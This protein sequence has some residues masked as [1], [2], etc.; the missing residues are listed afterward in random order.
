MKDHDH[1]IPECLTILKSVLKCQSCTEIS[2]V[3]SQLSDESEVLFL[4]DL[5]PN[6]T[7]DEGFYL[8]LMDILRIVIDKK[9]AS[10]YADWETMVLKF[11]SILKQYHT[12]SEI[13]SNICAIL[14]CFNKFKMKKFIRDAISSEPEIAQFKKEI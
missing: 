1:I 7:P 2:N 14:C 5:T 10:K 8:S 4:L 11:V 12:N 3:I 9:V 13:A 6:S